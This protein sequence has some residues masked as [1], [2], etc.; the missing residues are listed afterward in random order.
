MFQMS[1]LLSNWSDC[2]NNEKN[3]L[4]FKTKWT[5]LI[6]LNVIYDH[7]I[8]KYYFNIFLNK[9]YFKLQIQFRTVI[10]SVKVSR[11]KSTHHDLDSSLTKIF[12]YTS[13]HTTLFTSS[14][15]LTS[16]YRAKI[17]NHQNHLPSLCLSL[18]SH[19]NFSTRKMYG[20]FD[21]LWI[22]VE[23]GYGT[24]LQK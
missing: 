17:N 23:N 1:H 7:S 22:V 9:K 12:W 24:H 2:D 18:L 4:V 3:N 19:V 15:V 6:W 10:S 20:F 16:P 14:T 21:I 13:T 5:C 8:K 11:V